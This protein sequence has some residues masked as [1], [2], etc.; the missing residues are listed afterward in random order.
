MQIE[1]SC[2]LEIHR[3]PFVSVGEVVCVWGASAIV[4]RVDFFLGSI[5]PGALN[6][7]WM[8]ASAS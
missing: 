2:T 3:G 1:L 7:V 5:G 6:H 8:G 4:F